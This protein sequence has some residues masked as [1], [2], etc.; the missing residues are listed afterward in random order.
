MQ[1]H[2]ES[3]ESVKQGNIYY[4]NDKVNRGITTLNSCEINCKEKCF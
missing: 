4:V 1:F 3:L 2:N